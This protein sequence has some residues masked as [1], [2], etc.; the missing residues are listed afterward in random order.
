VL[1]VPLNHDLNH[2][3]FVVMAAGA[4]QVVFGDP[5][6]V[7]EHRHLV[8]LPDVFWASTL[9]ELKELKELEELVLR[10]SPGLSR[11][12]CLAEP[13]TAKG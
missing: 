12:V 7:G 8:E 6:L 5:G 4:S 13:L 2:R 9:K 1:S 10:L 11:W 3:F